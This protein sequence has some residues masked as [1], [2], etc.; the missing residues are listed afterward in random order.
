ME[1]AVSLVAERALQV[2]RSFE[3]K[4]HAFGCKVCLCWKMLRFI[5]KETYIFC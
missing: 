1:G 2:G 3:A 4:P 5:W